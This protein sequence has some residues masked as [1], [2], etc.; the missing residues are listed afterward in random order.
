[1]EE[2]LASQHRINRS[3]LGQHRVGPRCRPPP[4]RPRTGVPDTAASKSSNDMGV[5][6]TVF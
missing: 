2:I 3:R 6:W 5:D 1:V 4:T